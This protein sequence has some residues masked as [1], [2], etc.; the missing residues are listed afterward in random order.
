MNKL[1]F[2]VFLGGLLYIA[3]GI[4]GQGRDFVYGRENLSDCSINRL[5][6]VFCGD[7]FVQDVESEVT[8]GMDQ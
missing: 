8:I 1:V 5:S 7:S 2:T 6:K 4:L 3:A